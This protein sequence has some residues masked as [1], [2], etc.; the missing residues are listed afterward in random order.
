MDTKYTKGQQAFV[1]QKA[2]QMLTSWCDQIITSGDPNSL[3]SLDPENPY[4]RY[5]VERKSPWLS[6]KG[7]GMFKMLSAGWAAA[8]SFL[9][10]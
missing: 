2:H 10:R 4:V 7:G 6:D 8:A 1:Q 5:A 9:K 3:I